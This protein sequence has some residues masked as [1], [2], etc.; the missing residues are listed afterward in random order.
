ANPLLNIAIMFLIISG[1]LGFATWEDIKNHRHHLRKYRM[2]SKVILVTTAVL[3]A[4][5]FL[6]FFACEFSGWDMSLGEKVLASAF[7]AVTPRTAGF[8]TVSFS[9][10]K[11]GSICVMIIFML[12]GGSSGSTAGGMK[13]NTVAV[14]FASLSAVFK[15]KE[16]TNMFRRRI[17]DETVHK[18]SAI[19]VMYLMLFLAGGIAI[20]LIENLPLVECLFES[21]S[22][23][24]TV[25]LSMGLTPQLSIW[26]KCILMPLMFFGRV[27]GLTFVFAAY[28]NPKRSYA[29]LPLDKISVG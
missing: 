15:R 22:A 13:T 6:Y 20:S 5:P 23:V 12:I 1:G 10:M 16:D 11:Q 9:M 17:D 14:L 7:Q 18:A 21:A 2:Q 28:N 3:L 24:G 25:G 4:V 8:N 27:G 29:K 26:S 19:L